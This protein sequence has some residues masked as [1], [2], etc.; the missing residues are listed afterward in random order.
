MQKYRNKYR[1]ASLRLSNW[2]Y[3]NAAAYFITICTHNRQHYFGEIIC[4]RMELS[5]VGVIA[6]NLWREIKNH[7]N[8]VELGAFVVMPDHIHGILILTGIDHA[9]AL[10]AVDAL[11]ATH[12]LPPPNQFMSKISPK[13][14]SVSAIVRSYKSAVTRHVRKLGHDFEWQ[15]RFYDH[16]IR[17]DKSFQ[18]ISEYIVSNPAKWNEN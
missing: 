18:K 12:L 8:N 4:Q 11:H 13:R 14:G 10:H 7:T 5:P 9:D 15:N 16:I 3:R 17:D 2:D 1:S 6:D